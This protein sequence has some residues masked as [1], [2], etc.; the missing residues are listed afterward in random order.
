MQAVLATLK[1]RFEN[2]YRN[3]LYYYFFLIIKHVLISNSGDNNK[4]NGIDTTVLGLYI[5]NNHVK[6]TINILALK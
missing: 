6:S 1:K 2:F 5:E 4:T 3:K